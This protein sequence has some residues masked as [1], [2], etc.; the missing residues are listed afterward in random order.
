MA[1]LRSKHTT[2]V[3]LSSDN[4]RLSVQP[5]AGRRSDAQ[6]RFDPAAMMLTI[7]RRTRLA[8]AVLTGEVFAFGRRPWA[9]VTYLRG[10]RSP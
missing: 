6:V 7:F 5:A 8:R 4:G 3:V 1:H 9:A 10:M 2:P